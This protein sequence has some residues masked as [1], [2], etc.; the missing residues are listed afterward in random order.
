[1]VDQKVQLGAMQASTLW[2]R[3]LMM[4]NSYKDFAH[5]LWPRVQ[6]MTALLLTQKAAW[7]CPLSF[8]LVLPSLPLGP[9]F[10]SAWGSLFHP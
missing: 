5:D 1:M 8:P 3:F 10:R 7:L 4:M 2:K 9:C 6:G